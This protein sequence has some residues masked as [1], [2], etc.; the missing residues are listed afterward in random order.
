VIAIVDYG[1]GNVGSIQNM[2]LRIGAETVVTSDPGTLAAAER[3]I[4]PGVGHFDRAVESL[5]RL[6]L[7]EEL[8]KLVLRQGRLVLGICLGMQLL[9]RGSEEGVL[10]GLGW[11]AADTVRFRFEG[12]HAQLK[13]PHMG[14]SAVVPSRQ[15]ALLADL[16][17]DPRFYFVHSYHVRCDHEEDVLAMANYGFPFHAAVGR[18]NILGTQFHPEKSHR[19]GLRVL[20]NFVEMPS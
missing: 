19:F 18:G 8:H 4:L 5:E 12:E 16:G 14:W 3:I 7:T 13:V 1:M 11:I 20:K 10:P 2:L 9:G 15:S 17:P 6:G